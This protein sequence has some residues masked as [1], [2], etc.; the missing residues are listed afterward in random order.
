MALRLVFCD[1]VTPI[2]ITTNKI[3]VIA[4]LVLGALIAI[5]GI[6]MG[7]NVTPILGALL[8]ILGI[9][10]LVTPPLV[11][12]ETEAQVKNPVGMTLKRFPLSG[13]SDL[14]FDGKKLMH[15]PTG[16]KVLTLG[17]GV[18]ST[19]VA[20]LRQLIGDTQ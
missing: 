4:F 5:L 7:E 19:Q 18:D 20:K 11:I 12:T 14:F 17:A 8:I 16:K 15:A 1:P 9:L 2:R 3:F 10:Q 6:A 13:P